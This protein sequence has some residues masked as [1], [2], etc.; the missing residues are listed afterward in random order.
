[1]TIT[2]HSLRKQVKSGILDSILSGEIEPGERLVELKLAEQY[3]VSQAPVREALRDLEAVG[4][5]TSKP[6]RGTFA[7]NVGQ[8]GMHEIFQVRGA[9]EELATRVAIAVFADNLGPLQDAVDAMLGAA[10]ND[11]ADGVSEHSK[12]FHSLIV[13][14]A[15]NSI[16]SRVWRGLDIDAHTAVTVR[17]RRAKLIEVAQSHQPIVDAIA[18]GDVELAC[19]ITRHHQDDLEAITSGP[20]P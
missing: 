18:S 15:D 10:E 20:G 19:R 7:G 4:L 9:L 6:N 3:G 13:D 2:R 8:R 1:M 5:V 16:L 17:Q 14:A 11:D 12:A